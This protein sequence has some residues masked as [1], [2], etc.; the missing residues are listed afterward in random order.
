[1]PNTEGNMIKLRKENT[2][3]RTIVPKCTECEA[4]LIIEEGETSKS[5]KCGK[6]TISVKLN[7]NTEINTYSNGYYSMEYVKKEKFINE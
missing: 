4:F 3:D 5:C 1:V 7:G 6:V 2:K